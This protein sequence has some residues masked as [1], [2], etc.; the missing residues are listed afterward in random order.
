MDT[1]SFSF[2][3]C[4]IDPAAN[5]VLRDG[6]CHA[7]EPRAMD[8]LV[9]LCRR[10]QAVISTG[11]L[12]SQCWRDANVGD[13]PVHKTIAQ[14]RRALGDT[15]AAPRYIETIRKRGYRTVAAIGAGAPH[16]AERC[17]LGIAPDGSEHE[18]RLGVS[19]P[20]RESNGDWR[21]VACAGLGEIGVGFQ[22]DDS[23][24]AF[25]GAIAYCT[26]LGRIR[27]ESGWRFYA[28]GSREPM[29]F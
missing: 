22:G 26:R 21:C 13:N 25:A 4:R 7:V 29:H 10:P 24:A 3:A 11:Q 27:E 14:L 2:G 16:V 17:L 1:L 15:P 19:A 20:V 18:L 12:I 8:V 28:P 6:L 5:A 23:W 9:A